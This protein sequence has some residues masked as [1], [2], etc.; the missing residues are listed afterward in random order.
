V[1]K[2]VTE[3]TPLLSAMDGTKSFLDF[4]GDQLNITYFIPHL[5]SRDQATISWGKYSVV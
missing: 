4:L 3:Y 5:P 2:L 1:V